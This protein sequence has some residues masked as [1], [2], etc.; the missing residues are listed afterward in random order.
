MVGLVKRVMDTI[1]HDSDLIPFIY[2]PHNIYLQDPA[3]Y[4]PPFYFLYFQWSV[5]QKGFP[6]VILYA[7]LGSSHQPDVHQ[8][9]PSNFDIIKLLGD[10]HNWVSFLIPVGGRKTITS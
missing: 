5:F 3:S 2:H 9:E 1:E 8:S 7:T 4:C 10:L 6:I